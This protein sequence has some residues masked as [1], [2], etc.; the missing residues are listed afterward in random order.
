MQ[1]DFKRIHSLQNLPMILQQTRLGRII[2]SSRAKTS[3]AA[4]LPLEAFVEKR[5]YIGALTL[6][7]FSSSERSNI[8]HLLWKGYCSFHN[9]ALDKAQE[10]YI[11]LLS[12]NSDDV[13]K[14]VNL[15][16]GCVYFYMRMYTE[17]IDIAQKGPECS[18]KHRLM[19]HIWEKTGDE[20]K[21][22]AYRQQLKDSI[23][24]ED[25]LSHAAMLYAKRNFQDATDIY[26][27][28]LVDD[29]DSVAINLYVAMCYFKMV[30][31]A[32]CS[33]SCFI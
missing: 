28:F 18:L 3:N 29:K 1:I 9:G 2:G 20:Q 10:Y 17:A 26:K 25:L 4:V 8:D 30:R 23:H 21:L 12:I 11:D 14:D 16:L 7:N 15:Y 22:K 6:L 31:L 32:M 13:P 24:K 27:R 19:Y 5:D 33:F